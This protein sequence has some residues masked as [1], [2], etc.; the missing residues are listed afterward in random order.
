MANVEA[1]LNDLNNHSEALTI[2]SRNSK[3]QKNEHHILYEDVL[4]SAIGIVGP[5]GAGVMIFEAALIPGLL[6][7]IATI[8]G[9]K[10]AVDVKSTLCPV[11]KSTIH[12]AHT[13]SQYAK[14]FI[15]ETQERM[16]DILAEIEVDQ[17]YNSFNH[18]TNDGPLL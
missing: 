15:A 13:A 7:G 14:E 5:I 11:I 16:Q 4:S 10:H 9:S 1:I 12:S 17:G 18:K 3:S 6:L 8:A 2:N